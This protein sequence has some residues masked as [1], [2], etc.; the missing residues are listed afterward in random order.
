MS[1]RFMCYSFGTCS[2]SKLPNTN[3]AVYFI[4]CPHYFIDTEF[5]QNDTD[6]DERFI[7]FSKAVIE[8]L[9]RLQ[10]APNV[11]HCNDWQNRITPSLH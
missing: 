10:W 6:E 2:P 7:L 1:I 3:I 11:I 8:T 4:D 9:Q 5:I